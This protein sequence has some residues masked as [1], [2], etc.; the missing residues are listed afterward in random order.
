[1]KINT[2]STMTVC[3]VKWQF[4]MNNVNT[5]LLCSGSGADLKILWLRVNLD[6]FTVDGVWLNGFTWKSLQGW[7]TWLVGTRKMD[8]GDKW[9]SFICFTTRKLACRQ[10]HVNPDGFTVDGVQLNG[11]TGN[12]KITSL[13]YRVWTIH[14]MRHHVW[15]TARYLPCRKTYKSRPPAPRIHL[16]GT[17]QSRPPPLQTFPCETIQPNTIHRKAVGVHA[18]PQDFEI[19]TAPAAQKRSVHVVHP[20]QFTWHTVVVELVLIFIALD[21]YC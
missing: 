2:S 4:Q 13:K 19:C 17:D 8:S 18:Q 1:M 5:A 16:S 7:W 6:G 21:N 15:L 12:I 3:H 11:F 9:V 14:C 20:S 10:S